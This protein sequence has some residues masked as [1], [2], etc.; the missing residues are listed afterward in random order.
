MLIVFLCSLE[1]CQEWISFQHEQAP[2]PKWMNGHTPALAL[3][4]WHSTP[5]VMI[6]DN[7]SS[8]HLDRR[9][10][11]KLQRQLPTIDNLC[12]KIAKPSC[13]TLPYLYIYSDPV[14]L[15]FPSPPPK[16]DIFAH[17]KVAQS[18]FSVM[19]HNK[20]C[21][22]THKLFTT[23]TISRYCTHVVVLWEKSL[24]ETIS[25]VGY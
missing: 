10:S 21:T 18:H 5:M 7:I 14:H 16:Y 13:Q 17:P 23:E 3:P 22:A 1:T 9:N 24:A 4:V 15:Q 2:T 19:A 25:S 8:C 6:V 12:Q 20:I 11:W